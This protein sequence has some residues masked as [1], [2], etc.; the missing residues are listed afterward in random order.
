MHTSGPP[1]SG[2]KVHMTVNLV[3]VLSVVESQ[4]TETRELNNKH[5]CNA[6]ADNTARYTT[7]IQISKEDSSPFF[8]RRHKSRSA[9]KLR[10]VKN[11]VFS[12]GRTF[13]KSFKLTLTWA[14]TKFLWHSDLIQNENFVVQVE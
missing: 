3:Q 13:W 1:L 11:A 14:V 10:Q 7:G 12:A 6:R 5:C 4:T 2:Y 8:S 9:Q